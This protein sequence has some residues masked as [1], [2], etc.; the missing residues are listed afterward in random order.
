M[1]KKYPSVD[2]T[3]R[4]FVEMHNVDGLTS[5][6]RIGYFQ[7]TTTSILLK[8]EVK[9]LKMIIQLLLKF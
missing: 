3:G 1:T 6:K 4:I 5:D 8:K 9:I 7:E 2:L